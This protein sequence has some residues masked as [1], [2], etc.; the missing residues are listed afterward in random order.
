MPFLLHRSLGSAAAAAAACLWLC[1]LAG[2]SI[3]FLAPGR[4]ERLAI[5]LYLSLGLF[6]LLAVLHETGLSHRAA[7]LLTLGAVL[8]ATGVIFHLSS[9]LRFQNAIWHAFVLSAAV[10]HYLAIFSVLTAIKY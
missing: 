2:A 4:F 5:G 10:C 7:V 1:A 9:R 3:K 8:Y 6:G